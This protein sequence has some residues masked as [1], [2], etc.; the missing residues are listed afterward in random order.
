M[1][2]LTNAK[3]YAFK[4]AAKNA[5]GT[6]AASPASHAVTVGAPL[7]P[8]GPKAVSGSTTAATG[9]VTVSYTA[10]ANNG[11]AITRFT[12]TCVSS[13]GGATKAA[14]HTGA[15]AA[16]IP[17]AALTTKKTYTCSVTATNARGTGPASVSSPAVIVGVRVAPAKPTVTKA[18]SGSLKVTFTAPANNGAAITSYSATCTSS[19]GGTAKSKAGPGSPITVAGLT[20]GKTYTCTVSARPTVAAPDHRRSCRRR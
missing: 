2:G 11:S 19:N 12:A 8:T 7:A 5:V 18:A 6:G 9:T 1:T 3:A 16:P 10:G 14:T 15:T 17:V 13:N 4:V 20:A